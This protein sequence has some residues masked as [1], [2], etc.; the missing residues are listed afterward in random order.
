[1]KR[2]ELLGVSVVGLLGTG[3]ITAVATDF[4][5]SNE[6]SSEPD[7]QDSETPF[8]MFSVGEPTEE[9]I[10]W[11]VSLRNAGTKSRTVELKIT[12]PVRNDTLMNRSYSIPEGEFV[13]GKLREPMYYE[14][15]V[16]LE[17]NEKRH[18]VGVGESFDT[19]NEHWTT[20]TMT[21]NGTIES[22]SLHT[23]IAC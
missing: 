4:G 12:A 19:C 14:L 2:R 11:N 10:P 21:G 22:E 7:D 23:T 3:G 17:E 8:K 5:D 20:L 13:S 15:Q 16:T 6:S 9:V 18:V 1:M